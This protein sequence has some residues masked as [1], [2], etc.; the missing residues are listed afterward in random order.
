[1]GNQLNIGII[2]AGA[3]GLLYAANFAKRSKITLFTR[4]AGQK[5]ALEQKGILLIDNESTET[6]HINAAE[7]T[8]IAELTKQQFLIVAVKQYSLQ[9]IVPLLQK[10]P[11]EIPILFIQNGAAHLDALPLLGD[12]RTILLGVSEHGAGREN[13]TTVIWRGHGRTKYS[14]Y[15]GTL[16]PSIENW[17]TSLPEFPVEKHLSYLEIIQEKLF[18][19]AVI[20]PLTAVLGVRNGELLENPEWLQLLYSLV[21]EIEKVLP[22]ENGVE[23]VKAICRVTANNYSSMALDQ[24]HHRK[25]EIDGIVRPILE[26][27]ES[28]GELLPTLRTFYHIIKGSEGDRNV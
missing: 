22:V 28:E 3:M 18:I 26:K 11:V 6:I 14:L 8:D 27:G 7:V 23:K 12:K 4:R 17:L 5:N 20:N 2:G 1:M 24:K 9:E 16:N 15:Q 10:V 25:T 21:E 13:D 19:N